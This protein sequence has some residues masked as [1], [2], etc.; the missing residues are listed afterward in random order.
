MAGRKILMGDSISR[1]KCPY[2]GRKTQTT[3]EMIIFFKRLRDWKVKA[4]TSRGCWN[5]YANSLFFTLEA[6]YWKG[7]MQFALSAWLFWTIWWFELYQCYDVNFPPK[8]KTSCTRLWCRIRYCTWRYTISPLFV[9]FLE[10][11]ALT[12]IICFVLN[13][14]Q[15]LGRDLG[16]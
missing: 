10:P 6:C 3:W 11:K 8:A 4:R 13:A 2:F 5:D 14:K 1:R 9:I 16:D 12:I 15:M 7:E